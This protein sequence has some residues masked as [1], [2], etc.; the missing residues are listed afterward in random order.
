MREGDTSSYLYGTSLC[1]VRHDES[2][3]RSNSK[4]KPRRLQRNLVVEELLSITILVCWHSPLMKKEWLVPAVKRSR[5]IQ[6]SINGSSKNALT[7]A[8]KFICWYHLTNLGFER[9]KNS[10]NFIQD[11]SKLGISAFDIISFNETHPNSPCIFWDAW[12]LC[13][14]YLRTNATSLNYSQNSL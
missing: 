8:S 12:S 13:H 1:A 2:S 9:P 7:S 5:D 6:G 10:F 11:T 4:A 14:S 3:R